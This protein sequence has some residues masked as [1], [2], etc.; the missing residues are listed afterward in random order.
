M[1]KANK[2]S[3]L[4]SNIIGD[5]G[6]YSRMLT[7]VIPIIIQNTIT[8]VVSL[9]DNVMVGRVGTLEMSA[10]AIDNQLLF[11]FYICIFGGLSGAGIFA[12]QYAG[13]KDNNG[14]RNCFRVKLIIAFAMLM[15]AMTVF[16]AMPD[17][18]I[19]LYLA[20]E[21][22]PSD[23]AATL[24]FAGDY[25]KIMLWGLVPFAISQV[26]SSTLREFGETKLPMISSIAAIA[27]NL[28]FNYFLIFGT[29]GFP[30]LGVVGAAIAT[31][32][33]R[34]VELAIVVIF[35][36][37]RAE[38]YG[39]IQGVYS[40][41]K[42][43][44]ALVKDIIRRGMPLLLNETLWSAGMATLL[45]CYSVRGLDVVAAANIASTVANLFNVVFLS[46]GN[47]IA[48]M[49]GQ[50]LGANEIKEAKQT[51]WRLIAATVAACAVMGAI[52]AACAPFIPYVYNTSEAV[53]QMATRLLLVLAVMMPATSFAHDCYFTIRS[54]GRT[55]LTFVFDSAFMWLIAVPL[56]A[57][58][59]NFTSL[60]IIELYLTIQLLEVVKGVIGF[61]MVEKGIWI[62]NIII[63]E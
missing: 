38:K 22:S 30:K 14:V 20:E 34:Y 1:T 49:V 10:V 46:M 48:I 24:G 62:R 47:A 17:K 27:V 54:G 57:V 60:P 13:A 21:T 45:Q 39:F 5:R 6:F 7:I 40:S 55:L 15:I 28:V 51:A 11:V 59:A 42:I 58:L 31:A 12:T 29:F 19:S 41:L 53:R 32:F 9:L 23:A 35:T 3:S 26:Y 25:L 36:H 63:D 8:N 52:L 56:A 37:K 44:R 2:H 33:S 18:L 43:P 50:H 16:I 4:K 61:V